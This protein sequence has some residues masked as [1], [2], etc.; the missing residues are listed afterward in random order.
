MYVCHSSGPR[1]CKDTINDYLRALR[2]NRYFK[3]QKHWLLFQSIAQRTD[4]VCIIVSAKC[5]VLFGQA[6]T[7]DMSEHTTCVVWPVVYGPWYIV[8]GLY[9]TL[10]W[11][12]S[13]CRGVY[14]CPYMLVPM[15]KS[16]IIL[17]LLIY[18]VP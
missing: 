5:G 8:H 14:I 10:S 18:L 1:S 17:Y 7:C 13:K 4:P 2:L 16:V 11:H 15:N 12:S 3:C 9:H 6:K